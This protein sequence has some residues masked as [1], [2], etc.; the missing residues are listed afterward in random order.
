MKKPTVNTK[1]NTYLKTV[2]KVNFNSPLA[3]HIGS[4]EHQLSKDIGDPGTLVA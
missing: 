3:V 1:I 2:V 4:N